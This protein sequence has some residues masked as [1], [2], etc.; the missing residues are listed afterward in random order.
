MRRRAFAILA[1]NAALIL[2]GTIGYALIEQWSLIDSLYMTVITIASVGYSEVNPLTQGGRIFTILLILVG[3]ATM[4][5]TFTLM[6]ETILN[7]EIQTIWSTRRMQRTLDGL[8]DHIIVCGFGRVGSNAVHVLMHEHKRDIVVIDNETHE[9]DLFLNKKIHRLRGDAT[10]DDVLRQ[11]GIE[12]AWGLLTVTGD[13]SVNLF[14]VLSARSLN[15]NLTI[16]AR[17]S[18]NENES[19]MLRAGANR[20]VSPYDIG[21]KRMAHSLLRPHLTEFLDVLTG[22]AGVEMWLEELK[23]KANAQLVGKTVAEANMR[24]KTGTTLLAILRQGRSE[25]ITPDRNVRF[26]VDDDLI[27]IGTRQQLDNLESF[28]A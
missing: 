27:V 19:K 23:V 20:V 24:Q 7:S 3:V 2:L 28:M 25:V 15:P 6:V 22:D 4:A 11:A 26:E 12:R 16:V 17:S 9:D 8:Q 10:Q 21:G 5:T 1:L 18:R 14:I 13:D